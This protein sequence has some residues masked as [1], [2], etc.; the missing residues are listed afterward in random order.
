[1]SSIPAI[2]SAVKAYPE[3]HGLRDPGTPARRTVWRVTPC[4]CASSASV[5]IRSPSAKRPSIALCSDIGPLL[6]SGR[7]GGDMGGNTDV[8]RL[9]GGR[10]RA[11]RGALAVGIRTTYSNPVS[12]HPLDPDGNSSR[13]LL[14][15]APS[16]PHARAEDVPKIWGRRR[17]A[18]MIPCESHDPREPKGTSC[19]RTTASRSRRCAGPWGG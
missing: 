1:M 2:G 18:P 19:D 6:L 4:V 15:V 9:V 3:T 16:T 5:G 14:M 11:A 10:V 7:R 13:A 12:Q 8:H 17:H